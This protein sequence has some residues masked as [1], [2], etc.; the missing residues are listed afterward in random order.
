M[1]LEALDPDLLRVHADVYAAQLT[2]TMEAGR[3]PAGSGPVRRWIGAQLVRA[4]AALAAEP[5]LGATQTA[6]AS[7]Q[8][9]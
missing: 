8:G 1:Y 2:E 6:A 5:A 3:V 9:C 7:R 4:G